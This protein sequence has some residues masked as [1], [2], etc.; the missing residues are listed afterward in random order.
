MRN[1]YPLAAA[2]ESTNEEM[3]KRMQYTKNI[4][5]HLL[6]NNTASSRSSQRSKGF[7]VDSPKNEK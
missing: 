5:S 1:T 2:L 6:H 4:L 7:N 3:N